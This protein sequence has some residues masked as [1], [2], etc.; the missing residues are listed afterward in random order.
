MAE[1]YRR[2]VD[3]AP[4]GGVDL[5]RPPSL[6]TEIKIEPTVRSADA[7]MDDALGRIEMRLGLDHV[8]SRLQSLRARCALGR[9]EEPARQPAAK[10]LATDRPSLAMAIDVEI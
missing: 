3:H 7:D 8:Q 4:A 1:T 10:A 5:D 6:V 9:L 2:I